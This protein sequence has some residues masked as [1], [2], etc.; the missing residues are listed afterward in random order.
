MP[1]DGANPT[2]IV[3]AKDGTIYGTTSGGGGYGGECRHYLQVD[4]RWPRK[5]SLLSSF[6]APHKRTLVSPN[7]LFPESGLIFGRDGNL[8]GTTEYGGI[9][10][11]RGSN[12]CGEGGCGTVFKITPQGAHTV[13]YAF[14]GPGDACQALSGLTQDRAGFLYCTT[15]RGCGGGNYGTVY[16]LDP[17]TGIETTLHVFAEGTDGNGP[18]TPPKVRQKPAACTARRP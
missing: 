5:P 16:K 10:P 1:T 17:T 9:K 14:K 6:P 15:A 2:G 4:T 3:A 11:P 8:Y 13:L 12:G 7:G 18:S